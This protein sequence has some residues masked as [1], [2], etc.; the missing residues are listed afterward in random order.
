MTLTQ[1]YQ[2]KRCTFLF[3]TMELQQ[4]EGFKN[5][6][7][8]NNWISNLKYFSATMRN[9][10]CSSFLQS[11]PAVKLPK[12]LRCFIAWWINSVMIKVINRSVATWHVDLFFSLLHFKRCI[13]ILLCFCLFMFR[14]GMQKEIRTPCN[15]AVQC[16]QEK[17]KTTKNLLQITISSTSFL[18][19]GNL[20]MFH[21]EL[22][23]WTV[24]FWN[25][26]RLVKMDK[27]QNCNRGS[28][29][30]LV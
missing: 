5:R 4:L 16:N 24:V 27:C 30:K 18:N 29:W 20:E 19:S 13:E 21:N 12:M 6:L 15:R 23:S 9:S 10:K 17:N 1:V 7:Y 3:H 11:F 26:K 28:L 22:K 2:K 8:L 25:P 14:C